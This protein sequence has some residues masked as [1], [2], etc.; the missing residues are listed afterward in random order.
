MTNSSSFQAVNNGMPI[1]NWTMMQPTDQTS[2]ASS[3]GADPHLPHLALP[4]STTCSTLLHMDASAP[5]TIKTDR[6]IPRAKRRRAVVLVEV[7]EF[8]HPGGLECSSR[9]RGSRDELQLHM[10]IQ[11]NYNFQTGS[12]PEKFP[13]Q[14]AQV[15]TAS[16][17]EQKTQ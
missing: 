4:S 6:Q 9:F 2:R 15:G 7:R 8:Q 1:Y 14:E 16:A 5:L 17:P 12:L 10:N 11:E 3:K 13:P